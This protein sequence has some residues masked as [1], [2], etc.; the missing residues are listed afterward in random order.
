MTVDR[1]LMLWRALRGQ[2]LRAMRDF[3]GYTQ[4]Q[5]AEAC[6]MQFSRTDYNRWENG[7]RPMNDEIAYRLC[8]ALVMTP[9]FLLFGEIDDR[10]EAET[11]REFC[12]LLVRARHELGLADLRSAPHPKCQPP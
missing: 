1:Q 8:Q 10:F 3:R 9:N 7:R 4:Q 11:T 2:R 6:R 5:M 12:D